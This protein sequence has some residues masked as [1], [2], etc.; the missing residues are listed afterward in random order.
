MKNPNGGIRSETQESMF[1][2]DEL[3]FKNTLIYRDRT[4]VVLNNGLGDHIVFSHV[5]PDVKNAEVFT[6][7]PEV[8]AGRSIAEAQALFGDLEPYNVYAKMSQ[9]NWKG[10]L[11]DAY[12]KLYV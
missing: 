11:E 7:Y 5:L 2:H 6:C 8:V 10:T 9:W 3:I 1:L 12:R 4:I